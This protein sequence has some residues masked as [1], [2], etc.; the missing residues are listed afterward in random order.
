MPF[1][2]S[3]CHKSVQKQEKGKRIERTQMQ[4]HKHNFSFIV[5]TGHANV[6]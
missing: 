1:Q 4:G 5:S 2:N 3:S 6:D